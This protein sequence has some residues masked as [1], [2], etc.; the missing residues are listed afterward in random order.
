M[1][2]KSKASYYITEEQLETIAADLKEDNDKI[3]NL[4]EKNSVKSRDELSEM[5]SKE[6]TFGAEKAKEY[7]FISEIV[8]QKIDYIKYKAVAKFNHKINLI[9]MSLGKTAYGTFKNVFLTED[10]VIDLKDILQSLFDN[11][12]ERLSTYIQSTGKTY[13]D[14]KATILSWF[15]KDRGNFKQTNKAKSYSLEDYEMG[16]YLWWKKWQRF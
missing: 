4:Y 7:G 14:H 16:D 8:G 9:D 11:Y 2:N 13:K 3:L 5:M 12:I 10:E 15:Y 6:T 1:K